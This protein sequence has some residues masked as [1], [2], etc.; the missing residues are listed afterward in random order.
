MIGVYPIGVP[1]MYFILLW[2]QRHKLD[3]GQRKFE[4]SLSEE[5]ALKKALR[6][7]EE[8]EK[9]HPTLKSLS[10]LYSGKKNVGSCLKMV[11]LR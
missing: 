11:G 8:N 2:R 9:E 10:F 4:N 3:P 5:K 1:S 7:R 6:K